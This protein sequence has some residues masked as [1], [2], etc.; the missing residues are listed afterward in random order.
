MAFRMWFA[1]DLRTR[2]LGPFV[3]QTC[4]G[5]N[6]CVYTPLPTIGFNPAGVSIFSKIAKSFRAA[7][8]RQI[9][10]PK[11]PRSACRCRQTIRLIEQD[12]RQVKYG[13]LKEFA[14]FL[15]QSIYEDSTVKF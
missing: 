8:D 2:V 14:N 13:V 6:L 7:L 9:E 15:L 12:H 1:F 10:F 11:V 3:G 4:N 5:F